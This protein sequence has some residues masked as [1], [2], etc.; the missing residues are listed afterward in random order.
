MCFELDVQ[1]TSTHQGQAA[2][3]NLIM[4]GRALD[5]LSTAFGHG[6]AL[7]ALAIQRHIQG[8]KMLGVGHAALSP[9]GP[10][11]VRRKNTADKGDDGQTVLSVFAQRVEVPPEITTRW[12][13]LVKPRSAISVAAAKRPDM[14]AIGTPGPGCTL[15]PAV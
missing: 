13:R 7:A 10:C 3:A 11:V 2:G 4:R 6:P 8:A 15:P 5:V 1:A 9:S 14:A 12:D